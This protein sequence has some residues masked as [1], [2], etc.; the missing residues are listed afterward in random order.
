MTSYKEEL[1]ALILPEPFSLP[2]FECA[3]SEGSGYAAHKRMRDWVL[4]IQIFDKYQK[5]YELVH[6]FLQNGHFLQTI[7]VQWYSSL[8]TRNLNMI[9]C[10]SLR[11]AKPFQSSLPKSLLYNNWLSLYDWKTVES[12]VKEKCNINRMKIKSMK[13]R[14]NK[15]ISFLIWQDS[16]LSHEDF[17]AGLLCIRLT[18]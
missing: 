1:G 4:A 2:F 3:N 11:T 8:H 6:F 12:D 5:Y 15:K 14:T 10:I 13:K 7:F 17:C 9:I 18:V 16:N